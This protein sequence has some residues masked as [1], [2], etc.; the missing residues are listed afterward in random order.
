MP[1]GQTNHRACSIVPTA[2]RAANALAASLL[3]LWIVAI[4]V[5]ATPA[6]ADEAPNRVRI[7]Y[8]SPKS[9]KYQP[10]VNSLKANRALDKMQEIFGSFFD[11]RLTLI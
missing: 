3:A 4:A 2:A 6:I 11:C 8:A 1:V 5:A 10:L 9:Q 7:E